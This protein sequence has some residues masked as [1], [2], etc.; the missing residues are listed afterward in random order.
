LK[1]NNN[2]GGQALYPNLIKQDMQIQELLN[3]TEWF[4]INIV[5]KEIPKIYKNLFNKMSQN[6]KANNSQPKQ[7]F[8][9]ERNALFDSLKIINLNSLTLEQISFL[10]Q[11]KVVEL[12]GK[13]G[14]SNIESVLYK[15]NLDIATAANKISDFSNRIDTARNTLLEIANTLKKS[16]SIDDDIDIPEDSVMMRVY[17]QEGSSIKDIKDLKRLSAVWYD[18]GRGIAMAQNR[19]PEDFNIIGAQKGSLIVEMAVYTGLA[20]SVSTILLAGLKVAERVIE[21]L[22]KAEELK[23]LKL[24]NK[25]IEQELKKEADKVKE[26][27]IQSILELAINQLGL[28]PKQEGDKVTALNKSI[29]KLIDFTQKGGAVDFV[30][31]DEDLDDEGINEN[32]I[33]EEVLRLNDNVQEIRRLENKIKMLESKLDEE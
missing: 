27:G 21:I 24:G 25:Q 17:F 16:F 8:E 12:L 5:E 9:N 4:R 22:K 31:S 23:T 3:L 15:N 33:R 20:T 6:A 1:I 10:E 18:I 7:P 26:N 13:E 11:L 28:N 14:V 19:S 30:Q 2:A 29:T 32:E